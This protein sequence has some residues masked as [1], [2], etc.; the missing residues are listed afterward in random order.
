MKKSIRL[1][2]QNSVRLF[3]ESQALAEFAASVIQTVSAKI[4]SDILDASGT[5]LENSVSVVAMVNLTQELDRH[6]VAAQTALWN[7]SKGVFI[8]GYQTQFEAILEQV[9]SFEKVAP[10]G[11]S[12]EELQRIARLKPRISGN[13]IKATFEGSLEKLSSS[14]ANL[15]EPIRQMLAENVLTGGSYGDLIKQISST[16]IVKGPFVTAEH[17]A[18]AIA[19][20][21]TTNVYNTARYDSIVQSNRLLPEEKQIEIQWA[22]LIDG[23]TSPRCRSLN[24]QVRKQGEDFISSDGWHGKKPAAHPHCRSEVVPYRKAWAGILLQLQKDLALQKQ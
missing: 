7:H 16:G 21:E 3:D 6:L 17:R 23:H 15:R 11:F 9:N 22:S 13:L 4:K 14:A 1:I 8:D 10:S 18:Q 20:T 2:S 24:G 5:A 12:A 19:I